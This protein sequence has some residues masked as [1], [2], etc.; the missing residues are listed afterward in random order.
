MNKAAVV[1][2]AVLA[3]SIA[4]VPVA[5]ADP[6]GGQAALQ[7]SWAEAGGPFIGEWGAHKE[8]VVV[9]ADGTG[10]ETSNYGTVN[11]TLGSVQ[12]ST[13]PWDTAYGNVTSGSLERGAFV[14]LQL[15]D[16][17]RGMNFSAGGG[18]NNF[19][20]CK[21]VNGAKVNSDDCGA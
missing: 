9:N 6:G 7:K 19:P 17:G 15:V 18:D 1:I 8:R 13:N 14:T 21:I 20:F 12:T 5:Q 3:A 11:F 4:C 16:G 10:I 2:P